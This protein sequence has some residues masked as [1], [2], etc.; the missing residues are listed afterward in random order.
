M[1][2]LHLFYKFLEKKINKSQQI[3]SGVIATTLRM[4]SMQ[5]HKAVPFCPQNKAQDTDLRSMEMYILLHSCVI[6]HL[7]QAWLSTKEAT[8]RVSC[9]YTHCYSDEVLLNSSV[10]FFCVWT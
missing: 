6:F 7:C 3:P 10:A 1:I 5:R 4:P 9:R 8:N 2:N